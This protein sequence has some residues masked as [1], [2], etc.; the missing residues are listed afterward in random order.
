LRLC[1]P[2]ISNLKEYF[3]SALTFSTKLPVVW[4]SSD[5]RAKEKLQKLLFPEGIYYNKQNGSFRTN[6]VNLVFQQIAA[7]I[8]ISAN[9]KNNKSSNNAALSLLADRTGLEPAT[10]AVTGRHSNQLNYRSFS[11]NNFCVIFRLGCKYI[12]NYFT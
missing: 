7:V 5:V 4:V 9:H 2:S 1:K 3:H 11:L 6:K 10:S 12:G 8:S